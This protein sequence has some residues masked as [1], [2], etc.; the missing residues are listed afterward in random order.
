MKPA[1]TS[2]RRQSIARTQGAAQCE[3]PLPKRFARMLMALNMHDGSEGVNGVFREL[4][5]RRL[6]LNER[7]IGL[8][9]GQPPRDC[10][11]EALM[12]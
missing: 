4:G 9:R 7:C 2:A 12:S 8:D 3:G 11:A 6:P 5:V 1:G 10:M